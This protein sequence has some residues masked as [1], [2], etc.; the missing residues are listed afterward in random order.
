MQKKLFTSVNDRLIFWG[1][2]LS[3]GLGLFL[4]RTIRFSIDSLWYG[5]HIMDWDGG[6]HPHH[7]I[8]V[9][10][11][12]LFFLLSQSLFGHADAVRIAQL[13]NVLFGALGVGLFYLV[14][15]KFTPQRWMAAAGAGCLLLSG[16]WWGFST[17]VEVYIPAT[18]C[19]LLLIA[20]VY[21]RPER[22]FHWGRGL[23]QAFL[24]TLAILYHQASVLFCL[25]L[26]LWY[27]QQ[28]GRKGL[29][30]AGLVI[31]VAGMLSMAA[32]AAAMVDMGIPLDREGIGHFIFKYAAIEQ[33]GWGDWKHFGPVGVFELLRSQV[34]MM[35]RQRLAYLAVWVILF[36]LIWAWIMGGNLY[37]HL[38]LRRA[39]RDEDPHRHL[40]SLFLN[41]IL[42]SYL[43]FLWWL[44][45][46]VEFFIATL[47]PIFFLAVMGSVRFALLQPSQRWR[48]CI[49]LALLG[50]VFGT[51]VTAIV[52]ARFIKN[53]MTLEAEALNQVAPTHCAIITDSGTEQY[54]QYFHRREAFNG[55]FVLMHYYDGRPVVPHE[56]IAQV[57]CYA[58][59]GRFLL[60]SFKGE[61]GETAYDHPLEWRRYIAELFKVQRVDSLQGFRCHGFHFHALG[62]GRFAM[63]IGPSSTGVHFEDWEAFWIRL[64][65]LLEENG[66]GDQ[67]EF[68]KWHR[69]V[70]YGLTP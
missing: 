24:L 65:G 16:G 58:V 33:P 31:V 18:T 32:Y 19:L 14:A 35:F 48:K 13:H 68:L 44:P 27:W 28:A 70:G 52:K 4:F 51:N 37:T 47:V 29:L 40:R 22:A 63:V 66:R 17:Q 53:E 67:A 54:V 26:T 11:N 69:E 1:L 59:D 36:L 50:L 46:E 61:K 30:H 34:G 39:G 8:F 12:H 49:L 5:T 45:Q 42:V 9:P 55:M 62:A 25:P 21:L 60:P 15:K 7:L 56:D 57:D 41:W 38:R 2:C 20:D 10:L 64:D 23:L 43:F 6:Y 3:S